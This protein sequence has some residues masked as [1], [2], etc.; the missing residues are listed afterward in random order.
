[1]ENG[2]NLDEFEEIA[3]KKGAADAKLIKADQVKV[4]DWVYW[5]CRYGCVSYG[6]TLTCPPHSP[7]PD[8]TRKLLEGYDHALLLKYDSTEDYP[9]LLAELEKEAFLRGIYSAWGLSSG[10]CRL[11][12]DCTNNPSGCRHPGI[13]RPAMEACG[14]DVF[15]T[16]LE[17][18][19]DLRVKTSKDDS[20]HRICMILLA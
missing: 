9:R 14:I 4:A 5:K 7:T 13:A 6:K 16:A 3:I 19:W 10:A 8:Q 11:C 18:G 1:M 17:A 20:F 15:A 12:E 2:F